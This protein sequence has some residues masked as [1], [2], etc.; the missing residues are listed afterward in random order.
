MH[1]SG[2]T[3]SGYKTTFTL[4]GAI[5]WALAEVKRRKE[6]AEFFQHSVGLDC[7]HWFGHFW[8]EP[9]MPSDRCSC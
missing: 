6:D 2:V 3:N 4:N 9:I 7:P 1:L 8:T 5:I